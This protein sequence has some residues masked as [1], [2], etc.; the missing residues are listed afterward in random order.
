MRKLLSLA[1]L[2]LALACRTAADGS[3]T[4]P[5]PQPV[6]EA[7]DLA[8]GRAASLDGGSLTLRFERVSEDSRCPVD[9]QCIQAGDAVV[10]LAVNAAGSAST[11]ELHTSVKA[12]S[13]AK[14]GAYVIHLVSLA[15]V[16][17]ST[18]QTR[19]EDYVARLSVTRE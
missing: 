16:P 12:Q 2:S 5:T 15:P 6:G 3:P 4:D 14:V 9:V 7:F 17:R 19:A 18:V 10:V 8:A 13:S 1:L 11:V